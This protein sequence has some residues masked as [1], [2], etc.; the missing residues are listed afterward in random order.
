[1]GFKVIVAL[2]FQ[3]VALIHVDKGA[4]VLPNQIIPEIQTKKVSIINL[5]LIQLR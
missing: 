2:F 3:L 4:F 5:S 1:M